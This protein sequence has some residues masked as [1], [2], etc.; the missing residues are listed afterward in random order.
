MFPE[1]TLALA[2]RVIVA[3]RQ[4]SWMI[5]T[6]ESCTGGLIAGAL[7]E[8]SGSAE[9][10]HGGFVTYANKAKMMMLKGPAGELDTFG[11]VSEQVARLMAMGALSA[12]QVDISIA[13]TGVAGPGGGSKE[14]PVGLVHIGCSTKAKTLHREIRVGNI[15]RE[16]V[17]LATIDAAFELVLEAISAQA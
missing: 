8:I 6:A 14:K 12:A 10:V 1:K 3:L 9:V 4:N 11:A 16:A 15:G 7:T 2:Q 5:V 13:V 17:R